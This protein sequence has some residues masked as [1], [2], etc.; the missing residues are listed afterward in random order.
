MQKNNVQAHY[1]RNKVFLE[2]IEGGLNNIEIK[3]VII[4]FEDNI[5]TKKR[6]L[7]NL[8][9]IVESSKDSSSSFVSSMKKYIEIYE[10]N[11]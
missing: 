7:R 5:L 3:E 1:Q 9:N 4:N 2:T 10:K 11:C 6:K 8:R